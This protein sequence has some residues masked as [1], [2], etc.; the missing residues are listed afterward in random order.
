M[1]YVDDI[2]IF[3]EKLEGILQVEAVFKPRLELTN[4]NPPTSYL[5]INIE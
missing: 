4:G 1:L 3:G 2:L 5:G